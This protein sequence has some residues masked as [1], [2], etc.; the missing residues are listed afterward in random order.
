[1]VTHSISEALFL[2][3]RVIVFGSRPGQVRLN[4]DL[5]REMPRPR[6]DGVRYTPIFGELASQI[7]AA[8]GAL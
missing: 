1:M 4:L 7:R 6:A 2:A 8:I 3:D 5:I